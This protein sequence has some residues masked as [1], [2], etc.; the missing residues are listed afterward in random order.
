MNRFFLGLLALGALALMV[1]QAAVA[2]GNMHHNQNHQQA[3]PAADSTGGV[4][5][6]ETYT[7]SSAPASA[8]NNEMQPLPEDPGVEV[9]PNNN[10]D[11]NAT[12]NPVMVEEDMMVEQ[13]TEGE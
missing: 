8:N 11:A 7:A 10:S 4:M 9:A 6:I 2:G 3:N 12:E 5:I 13:Q 1:S